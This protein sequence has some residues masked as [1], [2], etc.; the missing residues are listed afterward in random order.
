MV[1]MD[2]PPPFK[3][4]ARG[5]V[6]P[7]PFTA[8]PAQCREV[9]RA[10]LAVLALRLGGRGLLDGAVN[11]RRGL[12]LR[13]S[14]PAD[15]QACEAQRAEN[16]CAVGVHGGQSRHRL[17]AVGVSY[18]TPARA[19]DSLLPHRPQRSQPLRRK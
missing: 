17:A 9:S 8:N 15:Q 16:V 7:N 10:V 2:I 3:R 19:F 1:A 4:M 5:L 14:R 6:D 11:G 12:E 18:R 13:Q